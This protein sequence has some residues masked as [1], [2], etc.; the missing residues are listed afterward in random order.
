V[1]TII[2]FPFVSINHPAAFIELH[3]LKDSLILAKHK[4]S[5]HTFLQSDTL[6]STK[7]LAQWW[8]VER[9]CHIWYNNY[10]VHIYTLLQ[11][12]CH[13]CLY[14]SEYASCQSINLYVFQ[15]LTLSPSFSL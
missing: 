13:P 1:L 15:C 10:I 3:T 5:F 7:Q 11:T 8:K 9:F 4:S 2:P 6:V 14:R 12:C